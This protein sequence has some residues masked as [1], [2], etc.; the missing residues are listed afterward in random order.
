[1]RI[2]KNTDKWGFYELAQGFRA[3]TERG[4]S[5]RI[6]FASHGNHIRGCERWKAIFLVKITFLR[7]FL[8]EALEEDRCVPFGGWGFGVRDSGH[9]CLC[10]AWSF[11]TVVYAILFYHAKWPALER[12]G[13]HGHANRPSPLSSS[14]RR[15][16]EMGCNRTLLFSLLP[17]SPGQA[18]QIF[19]YHCNLVITTIQKMPPPNRRPVFDWY[20]CRFWI[21]QYFW[22]HV[23]PFLSIY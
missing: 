14:F 16:R 22:C 12:R 9:R 4:E 7:C 13:W 5:V 3:F 18:C 11:A 8:N 6:R 1:M 17:I 2:K 19:F 20:S 15:R 23:L 10:P 21:E